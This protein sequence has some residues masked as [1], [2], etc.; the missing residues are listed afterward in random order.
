MSVLCIRYSDLVARPRDLAERGREFLGGAVEAE[1]MVQAV[2]PSL[3]RN[4]KTACESVTG[5]PA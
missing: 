1:R 3:Y 2:D 5:K 4:R